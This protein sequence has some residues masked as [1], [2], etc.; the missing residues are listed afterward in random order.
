MQGDSPR[1]N[2]GLIYKRDVVKVREVNF[3][4][5]PRSDR[6][7]DDTRGEDLLR[8]GERRKRRGE[9][10]FGV[11]MAAP[12]VPA[13]WHGAIAGSRLRSREGPPGVK[14]VIERVPDSSWFIYFVRCAGGEIYTGIATD[15]TRRFAEHEANGTRTVRF[16]RGRGPL[17]LVAH[18][19]AG[20]RSDALRLERRV[21]GLPRARKLAMLVDEATLRQA[22]KAVATDGAW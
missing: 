15:V 14:G 5:A 22:L 4:R 9:W 11:A 21:K 1:L 17:T 2:L 20:S 12:A 13:K 6:L 18:A 7:G 10:Y 19:P 8:K 16:L 3:N